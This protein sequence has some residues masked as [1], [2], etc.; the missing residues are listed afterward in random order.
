MEFHH[1]GLPTHRKRPGE[2][3]LAEARLHITDAEASPYGIEWLRFEPDSPLPEILKT[4]AHV[5]FKVDDVE[6]AI[7][8]KDVLIE[9]FEPMPGIRAAFILAD[10]APVE[11]MEVAT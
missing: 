8:G 1:V 4:T 5:A 3:Y 11:F 6:A 9:P 7:A 2:T 10:G